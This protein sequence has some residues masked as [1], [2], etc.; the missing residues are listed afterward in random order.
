M[1]GRVANKPLFFDLAW[2]NLECLYDGLKA[3]QP[4]LIELF[5]SKIF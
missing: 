3:K 1:I 5:G 4:A 2:V